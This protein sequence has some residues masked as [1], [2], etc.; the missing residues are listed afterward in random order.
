[1]KIEGPNFGNYDAQHLSIVRRETPHSIKPN[2]FRDLDNG[3]AQALL[4]TDM[5][6]LSPEAKALLKKLKRQMSGTKDAPSDDTSVEQ[7]IYNLRQ[8]RELVNADERHQA[9]GEQAPVDERPRPRNAYNPN[10]LPLGTV[11]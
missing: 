3:V 1:M 2:L 4:F 11:M 7:L 5:V 8:L 9:E 6:N 10:P